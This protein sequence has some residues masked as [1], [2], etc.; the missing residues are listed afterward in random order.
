MDHENPWK[1]SLEIV[2]P[3]C[4]KAKMRV[5]RKNAKT[6]DIYSIDVHRWTVIGRERGEEE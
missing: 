2:P 4:Y 3:K 6:N 5:F 1:S